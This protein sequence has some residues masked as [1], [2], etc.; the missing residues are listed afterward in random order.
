V[1]P[2]RA[3]CVHARLAVLEGD[4]VGGLGAQQVERQQVALRI[5]LAILDV[6]GRDDRRDQASD[7]G[8][9]KHRLDLRARCSRDH[10]H[11]RTVGG[12][13]HG[14]SGVLRNR[15]AVGH[16]LPVARDLLAHERRV[17][18]AEPGAHDLRVGEADQLAEVLPLGQR[19]AFFREE[20]LEDLAHD[21]FVVRERPVEVEEHSACGHGRQSRIGGWSRAR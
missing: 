18:L 2:G 12:Y 3:R 19:L 14:R 15:R 11:A 16:A 10:G 17:V 4:R 13:S 6:V 20:R 9:V 7:P 5:G 8:R 21:P 1:D